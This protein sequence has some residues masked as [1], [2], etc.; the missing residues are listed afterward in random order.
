MLVLQ[1]GIFKD[2]T[3]LCHVTILTCVTLTMYIYQI[4]FSPSPQIWGL[5]TVFGRGLSFPS[6][7]NPH[8]LGYK[9]K[10]KFIKID[11]ILMG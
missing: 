8:V 9:E 6:I 10:E 5:T 1:K 11:R 2:N 3:I 4:G 7:S